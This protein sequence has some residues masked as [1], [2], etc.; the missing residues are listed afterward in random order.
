MFLR[1]CGCGHVISVNFGKI[2]NNITEMVQNTDVV[3]N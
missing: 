1:G 2:S 3:I